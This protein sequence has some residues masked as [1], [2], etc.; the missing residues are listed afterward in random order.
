MVEMNI[1]RGFGPTDTS[2]IPDTANILDV[3]HYLYPTAKKDDLPTENAAWGWIGLVQ[4]DKPASATTA[5]VNDDFNN[6]GVVDNP[7]EG[8]DRIEI[9]TLTL[10]Q[11][12]YFTY[13]ATGRGWINKA[14]STLIGFRGG[15]DI[16]NNAL[17]RGLSSENSVTFS[18]SEATGT[19]QDPYM[20]ITYEVAS[21]PAGVKTYQNL[22]KE[23]VKSVNGL[24]IASNKSW[25]GL[26]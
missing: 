15:H 2:A 20:E 6:C 3:K 17:V 4:A 11:Y 26:Q 10:N 14:G 19:N 9:G 12:C 24:A 18:S 25:N 1:W 5:L 21:G 8:A 7:T 22:A 23:S 16:T 13:N